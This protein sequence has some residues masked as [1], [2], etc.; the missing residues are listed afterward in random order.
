MARLKPCPFK[1]TKFIAAATYITVAAIFRGGP[2]FRGADVTIYRRR[3]RNTGPRQPSSPTARSSSPA[4]PTR[5][6]RPPPAASPHRGRQPQPAAA[7]SAEDA[8]RQAVTFTDFDLDVR[9]RPADAADRRPRPAHRAQRRQNPARPH[10]AANL[11]LAQLGAHSRQR[12]GRRLPRRHAQLRRRPH[13]PVA[14][15]RRPACA[16][17]SPPA[18]S[19]QLDVTYSGVIA[20]SAQRLLAIGT[21]DDVALHSDWDQIGL[22]FTGLRG[23][24][25]VVWYPVSSVPVILGDGARALRRDGRAQAAPRR[26]AL[27]P[28]PHRRVSPR[29][30]AHRGPHQRPS[31][32]RSPSPSSGTLDRPGSRRRRHRRL[33]HAR[34]SASR[35]PASLSPSARPTPATNTTVWTLPE[36]EAAVAAWTTAATDGH[37]LSARL[38]GPAAPLPAHPARPA[39]PPGR[40]LRDRRAAGHL[41]PPGQSRAVGRHSGPRPHP[42]MDAVPARLAQ[43]G[44][45]ALHG[46]AV[47]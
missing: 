1:I 34:P 19:L 41:H 14:R 45:G 21:P 4:P 12:P 6:A 36:D 37:A 5:T 30:G 47:G 3:H 35:P 24:G 40:A 11:L 7:P 10:P 28:A 27:P 20:L 42:R 38:A 8:E 33:R 26:R 22:P 9:L 18:Q 17:R 46:H 43:R 13:R 25:N 29:P 39:R 16:S 15:S 44:S 32:R 31:R 23:F 2:H